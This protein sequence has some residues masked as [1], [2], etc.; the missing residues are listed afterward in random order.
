M[1][2]RG[3]PE[4]DRFFDPGVSFAEDEYEFPTPEIIVGARAVIW[5]DITLVATSCGYS[6][7]VME[8]VGHRE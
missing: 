5:I 2:E 7:P 3:T 1:Y 4:F 6:V 8:F